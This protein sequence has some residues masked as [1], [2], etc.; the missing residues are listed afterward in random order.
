MNIIHYNDPSEVKGNYDKCIRAAPNGNIY[1]LSWYLNITCP[2]WELMATDDFTSVM[3]LPV[4][5]KLNRKTLR[6]PVYTFQLGVFSTAIPDPEVI[7][8][9]IHSIPRNYRLKIL[10][11]NKFNVIQSRDSRNYNA[12]E[13]DLIRS[14][15]KTS[16]SY[17]KKTIAALRN[18]AIAQLSYVG[19]ISANDLL[20]FAYQFD[21]FN[22]RPLKP[23]QISTLRLIITNAI[24]YRAG[25]I[26]AAYDAH[27]N[28]CATLF[29]L[30]Y[31]GRT[32]IHHAAATPD[33]IQNG[34]LYFLLDNYI[35]ESSEQNQVLC[36]DDP[37]AGNLAELFQ[38]FGSSLSKYPCITKR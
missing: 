24:R 15:K 8:H 6:Q 11:L 10:C 30:I 37:T 19:G 31:N 13:L 2:D 29:F 17:S 38:D 20:M 3:P 5:I 12:S 4:F 36:M 35:R 18:A 23:N 32:S 27:N 34:A 33:G 9:F 7:R 1:A 25:R 21:V 16:A 22:S 14:Y 26:V 28:L